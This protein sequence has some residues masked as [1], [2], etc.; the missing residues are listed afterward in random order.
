M[1]SFIVIKVY[2]VRTHI[3][4]QSKMSNPLFFQTAN[5]NDTQVYYSQVAHLT[6]GHVLMLMAFLVRPGVNFIT[7]NAGILNAKLW[8]LNAKN[9]L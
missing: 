6:H 7:L 1:H 3:L 2:F 9:E 5:K 8:H 4:Y